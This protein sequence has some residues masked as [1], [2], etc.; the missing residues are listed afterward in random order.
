[1]ITIVYSA[2]IYIKWISI[3]SHTETV[4]GFLSF[5]IL[6]RFVSLG[7]MKF[8]VSG[9]FL[10]LTFLL[11][12]FE[13]SVLKSYGNTLR[14]GNIIYSITLFFYL[15]ENNNK[16]NFEILKPTKSSYF[17]YL[18]H[19]KIMLLA[20]FI[21]NRLNIVS[22]PDDATKIM[23]NSF[24]TMLIFI[25]C[26]SLEKVVFKYENWFTKLFK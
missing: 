8:K 21:I 3:R 23:I 17:I 22:G 25:S 16:L 5:F 19:P 12:M 11:S 2:N 24:L 4:M 20:V 26:Y 14:F 1:M 7:K 18:I 15:I 6:G 10:T 9:L 13:V